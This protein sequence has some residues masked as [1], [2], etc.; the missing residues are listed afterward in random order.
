MAAWKKSCEHFGDAFS[1]SG[2]D[3]EIKFGLVTEFSCYL[4]TKLLVGEKMD[5]A[6]WILTMEDSTEEVFIN[7]FYR[8]GGTGKRIMEAS[9]AMN[10]SEKTIMALSDQRVARDIAR[11]LLD[12][13]PLTGTINLAE[14]SS[15][16][17]TPSQKLFP[18]PEEIAIYRL[19]YNVKAHRWLSYVVA[20]AKKGTAKQDS[21][22]VSY[23]EVLQP[24]ERTLW[25]QDAKGKGKNF[26]AIEPQLNSS[27][28]RYGLVPNFLSKIFTDSLAKGYAGLRYGFPVGNSDPLLSKTRM[29]GILAEIRGGPAEG[30]R[31][32][33]DF[34]P[35]VKADVDGA[36]S[37]YTWSRVSFGWSFGFN[38][39]FILSRIDVQPR[40]GL[41]DFDAKLPITA[42]DG[43][44]TQER[45][46][47]KNA[48]SLGL[49]GGAEWMSPLFLTRLWANTD[50]SF[51]KKA[52]VRTMRAGLDIFIDFMRFSNFLESSLIAFFAA[53][54]I[55]L[56]KESEN[57]IQGISYSL[58]FAGFGFTV[59][60]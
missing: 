8:P 20:K 52:S 44:V 37:S 32:Y 5:N 38:P 54:S 45:F 39:N 46:R 28:Q 59:T 55:N 49:G 58:A 47:L 11:M 43:T 60:W 56:K 26:S 27:L 48:M 22:K 16:Y 33:W 14:A 2:Q 18:L 51:D 53:E 3:G 25:F 21:Y 12:L 15:G 36:E 13:V 9:Y 23:N 6:D 40:L 29:V 34:A 42:E 10:S 31:W 35:N 7:L 50:T 30:V 19:S 4:N 17:L 24:S 57:T 41:M 1:L